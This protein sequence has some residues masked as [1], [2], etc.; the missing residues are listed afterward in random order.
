MSIQ[1]QQ[2]LRESSYIEAMRY[3]ENAKE[4]LEKAGKE[5][6]YYND[7][8]YVST[9]CGTAYKGV[10]IALDAYLKL[11]NVEMPKRR[12]RT[13]DFYLS[14][15]GNIDRK[16]LNYLNTAYN[17]L[18]LDGYYDGIKDVRVISA[19]FDNARQIINQIKPMNFT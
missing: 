7:S 11:K 14:N 2:E 5:D 10:L 18:H 9:A 15:V 17:I 12:R 8:K 1:E 3:M 13:I 6:Y 19:G 16:L 4:T